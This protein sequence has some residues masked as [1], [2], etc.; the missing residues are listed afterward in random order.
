MDFISPIATEKKLENSRK[1]QKIRFLVKMPAK[2]T[3]GFRF[4]FIFVFSALDVVH[5][6]TDL[7]NFI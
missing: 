5:N 3:S 4:H 7:E 2:T 1:S 6:A